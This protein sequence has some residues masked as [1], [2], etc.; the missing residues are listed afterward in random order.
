M[1]LFALVLNFIFCLLWFNV[2]LLYLESE[3]NSE[4]YN[5]L[6][7]YS[8]NLLNKY[9][10][11]DDKKIL[12]NSFK[13][14]KFNLFKSKFDK[15]IEE[16]KEK[17]LKDYSDIKIDNIIKYYKWI[18]NNDLSQLK[19][20][21][22]IIIDWNSIKKYS[23][24]IE[25]KLNFLSTYCFSNSIL[26]FIIGEKHIENMNHLLKD[27]NYFNKLNYITPYNY[28]K[29]FFG[30][31]IKLPIGKF[32]KK[33]CSITVDQ[34]INDISNQYGLNTD[35]MLLLFLNDHK[36]ANTNFTIKHATLD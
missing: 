26:L 11:S 10:I 25:S 15:I 29:S 6:T 4:I 18:Q 2:S 22:G 13:I 28:S 14:L 20:K 31:P 5:N 7:S 21:K 8:E 36:I 1:Y 24:E 17:E 23:S 16:L 32:N 33:P 30:S 9:Y 19:D 3:L 34:I 27:I 35:E 12:R